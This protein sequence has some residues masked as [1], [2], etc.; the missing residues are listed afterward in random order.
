MPRHKPI[1]I[2]GGGLAGLT[3]GIGLRREDVP[4]T[5]WEAGAYPRHRVCGEFISGRGLEVLARL[6]LLEPVIQAGARYATNA[7]F[8]LEHA[9]GARRQLPSRALCVPRYKLDACLAERFRCLGGELREHARWRD[10]FE[11][12]VVRATGRRPQTK[13]TGWRWLGVKVHASNVSLTADLAMHCTNRGYVGLCLLPQ[14]KVNIC[15][16]FRFPPHQPIPSLIDLL[17]GEP[18]SRL[19]DRL[20]TADCDQASLC[21][22]SGLSLVPNRAGARA[23][24][25]LGDA[26]TMT[27]PITGNGMSMAFEAAEKAIAPLAAHARGEVAWAQAQQAV[28]QACDAAFGRRLAWAR[29][30]QWIMLSPMVRTWPISLALGSEPLW[31]TLYAR[32][33]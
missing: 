6:E 15:G 19:S 22:I 26:L 18:G 12:G 25:C 27:P 30:L 14:D 31:R 7:A 4:V 24:C 13:A 29:W 8:F 23:E 1:T 32:T 28:A 2:V 10:G 9:E 16:L 17:R 11:E 3:L 21:T 5:I 33:R 20:A